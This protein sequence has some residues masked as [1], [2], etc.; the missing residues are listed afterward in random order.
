MRGVPVSEFAKRLLPWTI[1]AFVIMVISGSLLVLAIPL[2]TYQSIFFR[3]KMLL[4]V[5]AGLNMWLFHS[6]VYPKV[7]GWDVDGM[8]PKEARVAGALSLLLWTCIV[9]SGRMIAYNW[10]DC[11]RQPQAAIVNFLISCV[12]TDAGQ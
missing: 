11:D 12:P 9:F 4:L 7:A 8:P 2:R 3:G 10:F 1:A 5:L 6:R